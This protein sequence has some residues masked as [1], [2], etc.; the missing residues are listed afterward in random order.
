MKVFFLFKSNLF[1]QYEYTVFLFNAY[2]VNYIYYNISILVLREHQYRCLKQQE[3]LAEQCAVH[4]NETI[5]EVVLA[6][7][8]QSSRL[9]S[10]PNEYYSIIKHTLTSYECK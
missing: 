1:K 8:N 6:L 2:L 3:K 4:R 10:S 7:H 5:K 9:L